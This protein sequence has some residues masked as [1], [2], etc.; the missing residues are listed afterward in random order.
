MNARDEARQHAEVMLA[1]AR[2]EDLQCSSRLDRDKWADVPP[3]VSPRWDWDHN[4]YRIKPKPRE[5]W[6][7]VDGEGYAVTCNSL[8]DAGACI[9]SR[10]GT[11]PPYT[12][13]HMREVTE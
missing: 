4:N 7:V 1:Y 3:W 2:G 9:E 6:Q 10:L 11:R 12:I 5:L 8:A 13:V